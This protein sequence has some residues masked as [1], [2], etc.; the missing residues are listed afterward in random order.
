MATYPRANLHTKGYVI[1]SGE[2]VFDSLYRLYRY[3]AL[4]YEDYGT[5]ILGLAKEGGAWKIMTESW[6]EIWE[7]HY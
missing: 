7:R 6:V 3:G 1:Q 5:Y 2:A 4:K